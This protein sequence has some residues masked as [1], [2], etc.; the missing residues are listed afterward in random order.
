M[1]LPRAAASPAQ[2]PPPLRRHAARRRFR[3]W[4]LPAL[5]CRQR[6]VAV[7]FF[8][9][10]AMTGVM[11]PVLLACAADAAPPFAFSIAAMPYAAISP[12]FRFAAVCYTACCLPARHICCWFALFSF[13]CFISLFFC[14]C[15]FSPFCFLFRYAA[16]F[17]YFT[18]A[19]SLAFS[20]HFDARFFFAAS[21]LAERQFSLPLV[22][23]KLLFMI[24]RFRR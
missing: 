23:S 2:L 13:A 16:V 22:F 8:D 12:L 9:Y 15:H 5:S 7:F 11:P 3:H 21:A 10:F 20:P 1:L 24:R 14:R 17:V 18:G 4:P 6:R 19:F